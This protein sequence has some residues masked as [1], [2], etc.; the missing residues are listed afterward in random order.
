MKLIVGLGN[1]GKKY[2]KT[3]HNIGFMVMDAL[4]KDER[5]EYKKKFN[6]QICYRN[7]MLFA[8]PQTFMNCSGKSIQLLSA[9]YKLPATNTWVVHDEIDLPFGMLRI[10]VGGS[11]AGHKGVE[12]I[13]D[14][15]KTRDFVRFR[16]GISQQQ[17]GKEENSDRKVYKPEVEKFV[18][19][20][21]TSKEA[22]VTERLIEKTVRAIKFAFEKGVESAMNE[23]N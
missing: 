22:E 19:Q 21:F 18:L 1:P 5:W 10:K 6:A 11:S 13:I 14:S 7:D 16:L 17:S 2:V 20:P 4:V 8:K 9:Y 12:S 15:L 23:F 3:R